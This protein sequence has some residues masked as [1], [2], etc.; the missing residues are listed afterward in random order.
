[1]IPK[2]W[3]SARWNTVEPEEDFENASTENGYYEPSINEL[4]DLDFGFEP[5]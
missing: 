4:I 2:P 5:F 3:W 1:M